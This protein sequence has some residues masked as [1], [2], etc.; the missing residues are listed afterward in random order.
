MVQPQTCQH[1]VLQLLSHVPLSSNTPTAKE[2]YRKILT[3]FDL[4]YN[5]IILE[6]LQQWVM[7]GRY[8]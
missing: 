2:I 3:Y 8:T 7:Y 1:Q 5:D 6:V 4:F